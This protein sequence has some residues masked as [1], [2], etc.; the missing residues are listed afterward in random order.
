MK[1]DAVIA[2][3]LAGE[4]LHMQLIDGRREWWFEQPRMEVS[5][6]LVQALRASGDAPIVEAGDSLFGL[7]DNSQTWGGRHAS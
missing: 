4:K 5:D 2:R 1:R 7:P 6:K 3:L